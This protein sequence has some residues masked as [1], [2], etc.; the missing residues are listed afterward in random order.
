MVA[1][2]FLGTATVLAL[3]SLSRRPSVQKYFLTQLSTLSKYDIQAKE[4]RLS[5]RSGIGFRVDEIVADSQLRKEH[6][7]A[8][9]VLITLNLSELLKGRVIPELVVISR[10]RI[11]LG[12][13]QASDVIEREKSGSIF[14]KIINVACSGLRSATILQG[15]LHIR[16]FPIELKDLNLEIKRRDAVPAQSQVRIMGIARSAE[17][18]SSFA[19]HGTVTET[20]DPIGDWMAEGTLTAEEF[21]LAWI[22]DSSFLTFKRGLGKARIKWKAG[23]KTVTASGKLVAKDTG[24]S[25]NR[26]EHQT[27]YMED[28]LE[29]EFSTHYSENVFE[30]SSFRLSGPDFIVS[31]SSR[32]DFNGSSNPHISFDIKSPFLPLAT[33][34]RLFPTCLVPNWVEQRIFPILSNGSARLSQCSMEGTLEQILH[35]HLPENKDIFTLQIDWK[36]LEV[37]GGDGVLPFENVSGG[38]TIQQG[39]LSTAVADA[40][41]GNST[42]EHAVFDVDSLYDLPRYRLTLEGSFD[43]IDVQT[44]A[45]LTFFPLEERRFLHQFKTL[46]GF[47]EGRLALAFDKEWSDIRVTQGNLSFQKCKFLN[48]ALYFPLT[49]NQAN[50]QID[51][52]E[53]G[54]FQA[55]GSWGG[56]E[57]NLTGSLEK[58]EITKIDIKAGVELRH[59]MDYF[60]V[61]RTCPITQKG[62]LPCRAVLSTVGSQW[63][64]RGEMDI[65]GLGIGAERISAVAS[66]EKD[67]VAFDV[68]SSEEGTVNINVLDFF[69][70]KSVVNVRGFFGLNDKISSDVRF[71]TDRLRFNDLDVLY[72]GKDMNA[73]GVISCNTRLTGRLGDG[74]KTSITGEIA[75]KEI[76]FRSESIP[77]VI[78]EGQFDC[79]FSRKDVLIQSVHL[80]VGQSP[81]DIQGRLKGWDGLRG[82]VKIHA[83]LFHLSDFIPKEI[84]PGRKGVM[85]NPFLKKSDIQ[86]MLT[87]DQ[88][89]WKKL[90]FGPV[91][92]M[93]E[94]VHGDIR[95]TNADI[96]LEH[97]RVALKGM[98]K[99]AEGPERLDFKAEIGLEAQ[100]VE[101]LNQALGLKE[102]VEGL[103]TLNADLSVKTRDVAGILTGLSGSGNLKVVNGR[104][105]R[106]RGILFR[107]LDVL[108]LQNILKGRMPEFVEKGFSFDL[109]EARKVKVR[110]GTI[111][112]QNLIFKSPV[113]N[114]AAQGSVSLPTEMLDFRVWVQTLET[115]DSLVAKVP[116]IGYILTEKE[117]SPRGVLIYP[118]EIKG[119]W[120]NPVITS[121][122]IKNIGPGVVN[123]FKKIL[124]TPGRIFREISDIATG[125]GSAQFNENSYEPNKA[126]SPP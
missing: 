2:I 19:L 108:N 14:R 29:A 119:H 7:E 65:G 74:R 91:K 89:G 112:T 85:L 34:T 20:L 38:L 71:S 90:S 33:F 100:P 18:R 87:A 52:Q 54:L 84:N 68:S 122:V 88:G 121:A 62:L 86:V 126:A 97:G 48:Q 120:S 12:P 26:G 50:L 125:N 115:V 44:Q 118:Y 113:F 72:K 116:I 104:V 80:R 43:L 28:S 67:R 81:L 49:L 24:F 30:V 5:L 17:A 57:F 46:S 105:S 76:T 23:E 94:L 60:S 79:K 36:G 40:R 82:N 21:P 83:D 103:L 109:L 99:G 6:I 45:N 110:N 55:D 64:C 39:S 111:E 10:P 117:S 70:G 53:K 73:T 56:S 13:L 78:T 16:D 92:A 9:D 41:F 8:E 42:V 1:L 35:L 3:Y 66:G 32:I 102:G 69:L 11:E 4:I 124:L 51:D 61:N 93:G 37:V 22:P 47:V 59:I 96:Q 27:E 58:L 98:M 77:S 95:L 114:A 75:G 106:K 123:I 63:S 101:D 15:S 31:A 107:L 25:I